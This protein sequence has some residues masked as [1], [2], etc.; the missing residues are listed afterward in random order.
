MALQEEYTVA[1]QMCTVAIS[2]FE[3]KYQYRA[4]Q[5]MRSRTTTTRETMAGRRG[6]LL[7]LGTHMQGCTNLVFLRTSGHCFSII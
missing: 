2:M 1:V 3:S 5:V 4:T 7:G 6:S